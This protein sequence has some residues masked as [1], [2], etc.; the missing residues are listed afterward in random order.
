MTKEVIVVFDI[1]GK[2]LYWHDQDASA[3][4]VPDSDDLF[5]FLW[6]HRH[7]LGGYA[8]THP[9]MGKARPSGIDLSTFE[10]LEKGLGKHLLWPILTFDNM[11]CVVRNP[12]YKDRDKAMW[13]LAGPLTV[14]FDWIDELRRRS[15]A[16]L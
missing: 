1:H 13:T 9:G 12:L 5:D 3:G 16:Q 2:A 14:E 8:H 10:A 11:I 15:G 7:H 6:E 4:Y